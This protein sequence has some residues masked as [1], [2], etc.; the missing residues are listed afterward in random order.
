VKKLGRPYPLPPLRPHHRPRGRKL[1]GSLMPR[2][3]G[4]ILF[5]A[6]QGSNGVAPDGASEVIAVEHSLKLRHDE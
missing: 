1:A 3:P 2:L 4:D 6:R 5:R